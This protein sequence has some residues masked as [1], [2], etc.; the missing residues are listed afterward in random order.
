MIKYEDIIKRIA[1]IE[2]K[3]IKNEERIKALSDENNI[4]TANL[5]LLNQK[6]EMLEKNGSRSCRFD[7][8]QEKDCSQLM[9]TV[10]TSNVF[11]GQKTSI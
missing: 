10:V 5:K 7:F 3:K 9:S 2:K 1:N 4:L 8:G 11:W 6:K